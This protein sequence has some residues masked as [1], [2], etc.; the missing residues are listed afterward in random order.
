[1][2]ATLI[3]WTTLTTNCNHNIEK[4]FKQINYLNISNCNPKTM[5]KSVVRKTK[6]VA[7]LMESSTRCST[8]TE[9]SAL[10]NFKVKKENPNFRH[11]QVKRPKQTPTITVQRN[12]CRDNYFFQQTI[13]E[14]WIPTKFSDCLWKCPGWSIS[15]ENRITDQYHF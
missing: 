7:F 3:V 9:K 11:H 13:Q 12:C 1:M 8:R 2:I 6:Q 4:D 10:A 14:N 5:Y 15:N